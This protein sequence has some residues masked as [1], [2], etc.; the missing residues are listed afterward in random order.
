MWWL[1]L[2]VGGG[3]GGVGGKGVGELGKGRTVLHNGWEKKEKSN[4]RVR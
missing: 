2:R 1:V 3:K 4:C